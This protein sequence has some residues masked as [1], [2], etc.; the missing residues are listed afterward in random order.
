MPVLLYTVDTPKAQTPPTH[1]VTGN[2]N[3]VLCA[4]PLLCV[5]GFLS[6]FVIWKF[7]F[8]HSQKSR[9]LLFNNLK[10]DKLEEIYRLTTML[11]LPT[12]L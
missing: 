4:E 3:T 1:T 11:T 12:E 7:Q 8:H 9:T 5:S 6:Q 10:T 2:T